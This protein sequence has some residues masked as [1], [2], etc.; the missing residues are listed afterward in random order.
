MKN[1]LEELWYGNIAPIDEI[2]T[3]EEMN[4]ERKKLSFLYEKL[5]KNLSKE[6]KEIF[7]EYEER[8]IELINL[9]ECEIFEYSFK[10]GINF[11][12]EILKN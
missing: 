10:L 1:L 8:N 5:I 2:K 12:I 9:Y 7:D 11:A 4:E 6:Q 3:T